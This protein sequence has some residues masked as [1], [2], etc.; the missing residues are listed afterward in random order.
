MDSSQ[1]AV[2]FQSPASLEREFD[3]PNGG[4]VKG[5]AIPRGIT[6]IVGGGFHGPTPAIV[7]SR[8]E[9]PD[10]PNLI[11]FSFSFSFSFSTRQVHVA[12][13]VA[14]G[15]LQ[16]NTRRWARARRDRCR[17]GHGAN[18]CRV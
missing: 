4:K 15:S 1:E 2:P 9:R 7:S 3:L 18:S 12:G 6:L 11:V 17:R 14:G 16:Q 5:M 10:K 8:L 13:G